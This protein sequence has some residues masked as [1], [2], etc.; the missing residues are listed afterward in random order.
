MPDKMIILEAI[1]EKG[2]VKTE[3]GK[4]PDA[5]IMS[6]GAAASKGFLFLHGNKAIYVALPMDTMT[7]ILDLIKSLAQ[8]VGADVAA[9]NG[10]GP[11]AP[12]LAADMEALSAEVEQLKENMQ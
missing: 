11:I 1:A 6:N 3:G 4:V 2:Q 12:A 8:K 10:G 9:S 7:Q 5:I